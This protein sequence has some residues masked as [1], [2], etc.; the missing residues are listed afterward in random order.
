MKKKLRYEKYFELKGPDF[1]LRP[2]SSLLVEY[3]KNVKT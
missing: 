2:E 3:E 1:R